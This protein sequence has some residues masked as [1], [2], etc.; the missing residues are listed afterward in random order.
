MAYFLFLWKVKGP[1]LCWDNLQR[2]IGVIVYIEKHN[3]LP[4]CLHISNN[5]LKYKTLNIFFPLNEFRVKLNKFRKVELFFCLKLR[6]Q[7]WKV[8]W[9]T[10]QHVAFKC[11]SLSYLSPSVLFVELL[12]GCFLPFGV[13]NVCYC[14]LLSHVLYNYH[15]RELSLF[16]F[17]GLLPECLPCRLGVFIKKFFLI[18][19]KLGPCQTE[20]IKQKIL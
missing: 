5:Q 19:C 17:S 6:F 20:E 7:G 11:Y 18:N 14:I 16:F 8:Q 13:T 10:N 15:M 3:C 2:L 4:A 1:R 12:D 9:L